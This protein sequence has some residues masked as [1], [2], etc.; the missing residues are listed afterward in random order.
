MATVP[1]Q[2]PQLKEFGVITLAI[3]APPL[4]KE[5][6][7]VPIFQ[8]PDWQL[9]SLFSFF[10]PSFRSF[11]LAPA[12]LCSLCIHQ[13][14]ANVATLSPVIDIRKCSATKSPTRF[15]LFAERWLN[16]QRQRCRFP[17]HQLCHSKTEDGAKISQ[18]IMANGVFR[19]A[20]R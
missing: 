14:C 19:K 12:F 10:F 13:F 3:I 8:R 1:S 7:L 17:T 11:F 4:L 5:F 15:H 20:R 2:F 6:H 9:L 18:L 16:G